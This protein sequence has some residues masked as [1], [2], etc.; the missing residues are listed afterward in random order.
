MRPRYSVG[1]KVRIRSKGPFSSILDSK[2]RQYEN[3]TGE[4]VDSTNVVAFIGSSWANPKDSSERVTIFHYTVRINDNI[5]LH[6]VFEEF[7]EISQ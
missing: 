4:I 7:L 3:M 5:T 2:I 1:S 6:D